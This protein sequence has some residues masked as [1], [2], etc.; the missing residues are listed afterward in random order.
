MIFISGTFEFPRLKKTYFHG[1]VRNQE[2][3]IYFGYDDQN[4]SLQPYTKQG[5]RK[6]QIELDQTWIWIRGLWF[7]CAWLLIETILRTHQGERQP[8]KIPAWTTPLFFAGLSIFWVGKDGW[9]AGLAGVQYDALGT[10]WFADRAPTWNLFLDQH[11][12]WP[13]GVHYNRLDSFV[14]YF[15]SVLFQWIPTPIWLPIFS[16]FALTVSGWSAAK[17]AHELGATRLASWLAGITF[18]FHG[19]TASALL[20]GHVYHLLLPWLPLCLLYAWRATKT[21]TTTKNALYTAFY[22]FLCILTSAYLGL[23]TT[24]SLLII[25]ILRKGWNI[26]TTY[27]GMGCIGLLSVSYLVLYINGDAL[28][29]GR[30]ATSMMVGSISL[31]NFFGFTPQVDQELHAQSLGILAIPLFLSFAAHKYTLKRQDTHILWFIALIALCFGFGCFV[32]FASVTPIFPMPLLWLSELPLFR[33]IGFPIRLSWPFVLCVG[34]LA[35]LTLSKSRIVLVIIAFSTVEVFASNRLS[36]RQ[37]QTLFELPTVYNNTLGASLEL[38]PL[39]PSGKQHSDIPMWL[40]AYS[41][42]F[43]TMHRQPIGENCVSTIPNSHS[44]IQTS[45]DFAQL[46]LSGHTTQ[47]WKLLNEQQFSHVLLYPDLYT[48][49]DYKRLS[50]AL[51]K[52]PK[53]SSKQ[54][55]YMERYETSKVEERS[56]LPSKD[57]WGQDILGKT[58]TTFIRISSD[59]PVSYL[60]LNDQKHEVQ[61]EPVTDLYKAQ[62]KQILTEKAEVILYGSGNKPIWNGSFFPTVS[63]ES[64]FIDTKKGW[65]LASPYTPSNPIN[66]EVGEKTKHVWLMILLCSVFV[67]FA[68]HIY[69]IRNLRAQKDRTDAM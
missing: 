17:F 61:K 52:F 45:Q 59:S 49:G 51:T 23:A 26:K 40:S 25:W 4:Q 12:N 13:E 48:Q 1:I 5:T 18:M 57:S 67:W 65:Q 53:T 29:S 35:S 15:L 9:S 33:S 47:A 63:T 34:V 66:K 46:L 44:R 14:F 32:S 58:E 64:L 37:K 3:H 31:S 8:K 43:Q 6:N 41:C 38:Y 21:Q 20:E 24:L 69:P 28:S 11:T 27:V 42:F 10:Y 56:E 54:I 30:D 7:V 68:R 2:R 50:H 36:T 60:T 19:L 55:W 62:C 16:V 22:W 39:T